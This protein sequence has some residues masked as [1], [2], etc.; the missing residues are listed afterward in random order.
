VRSDGALEAM[1]KKQTRG[2]R[3]SLETMEVDKIS[4]RSLPAFDARRKRRARPKEFSPE[5]LR[6]APG[7]PPRGAVD[8]LASTI[9]CHADG[10][11]C[12][13]MPDLK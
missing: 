7:Y 11:S 9:R 1:E 13:R 8:I 10:N 5:R 4:I 3:W 12:V 2:T 6:M